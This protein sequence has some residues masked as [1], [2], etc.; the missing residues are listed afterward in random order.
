MTVS[1]ALNGTGRIS[2]KRR[3]EIIKLAENLNYQPNTLAQTLKSKR[4][5]AIGLL[6]NDHFNYA[7]SGAISEL[8]FKFIRYCEEHNKKYNIEFCDID[9]KNEVPDILA[10]GYVGGVVF[11]GFMFENQ[12]R[13]KDWLGAHTD[14][15]IVKFEEPYNYSVRT[16]YVN[17]M[18]SALQYLKQHGHTRVGL[19]IG[20]QQFGVHNLMSRGF[21]QGV[22]LL[23][24]VC[25]DDW[26]YTHNNLVLPDDRKEKMAWLKKIMGRKE[27]PTAMICAGMGAS[28]NIINF[29]MQLGLDVPGDL[30]V[31]GKGEASGALAAFPYITTIERDMDKIIGDA[32]D[33]LE[34]RMKGKNVA[35]GEKWINPILVERETVVRANNA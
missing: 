26:I 6:I 16:D 10:S 1:S 13:F 9:G 5:D 19:H 25:R 4:K 11:A 24:M 20:P 7:S 21:S 33:I 2:D 27:R 31:I 32:F 30:S 23:S 3:R 12:T 34:H 15:P 35:N 28:R 18:L 29:A 17:G 22:D 14:F 8:T